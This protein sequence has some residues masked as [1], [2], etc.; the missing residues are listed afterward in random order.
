MKSVGLF[1]N[2]EKDRAL[3][4]TREI[5]EWLEN[6]G[7]NVRL[8]RD[9]SRL[10]SR[11]ELGVA[12]WEVPL[13]LLVVLGGDGTLLNAAKAVARHTTPILGVNLG[14]LGFLTE[15]EVGD[16]YQGLPRVLGGDYRVEERMMLEASVSR[17]KQDIVGFLALNEVVITKGPFARLIRLEVLIDDET[18]DAYSADG[19]IVSTPTGSTAYSLSAGG[20]IVTPDLDVM[21]ITP[22][23]P[24]TL[25]W[26]S[27][28]I[29]SRREVRI[30]MDMVHPETTL[31]MDGQTGFRLDRGDEVRITRSDISARLVRLS[32]RS[33]FRLLRTKLK[34][35]ESGGN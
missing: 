12:S 19:V 26:R 9:I 11:E 17:E 31:T 35:G 10:L 16:L 21:I 15:L 28:V 29:A 13:D 5:L 14:H 27:L 34:E 23:C 30:K 33:F 6:H 7:V 2:L 8:S 22:I 3:E 25:Y 20:P 24:H 18:V 4:I 32:D 1:P